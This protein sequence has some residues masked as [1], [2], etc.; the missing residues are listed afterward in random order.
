MFIRELLQCAACSKPTT[1]ARCDGCGAS[2][3]VGKYRIV[4]FLSRSEHGRVYAALADDGARVTL[5]ELVFAIVP[6]AAQIDA[7]APFDTRQ[8]VEKIL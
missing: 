1:A 2:L 5:K 8:F 4:E 7:F 3:Q 6:S